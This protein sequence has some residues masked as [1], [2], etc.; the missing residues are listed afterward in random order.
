MPFQGFDV[1]RYACM[2]QFPLFP[3]RSLF[4][5]NSTPE[6]ASKILNLFSDI[7]LGWINHNVLEVRFILKFLAWVAWISSL[8]KEKEKVTLVFSY[9]HE[10]EPVSRILITGF[11]DV[12]CGFMPLNLKPTSM[13]GNTKSSNSPSSRT[14][15]KWQFTSKVDSDKH[16]LWTT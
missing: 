9:E 11:R 8:R 14:K 16:K 1:G 15:G 3:W 4:L 5:P 2:R 10:C 7:L 13:A 12:V 6:L